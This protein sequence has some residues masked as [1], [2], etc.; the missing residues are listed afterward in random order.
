MDLAFGD[1][2]LL[3]PTV[4][5]LQ[6]IFPATTSGSKTENISTKLPKDVHEWLMPLLIALSKANNEFLSNFVAFSL[7]RIQQFDQSSGNVVTH[8]HAC[9]VYY[10]LS[11]SSKLSN[12]QKEWKIKSELDYISLL[13]VCLNNPSM[14]NQL[15]LP[16]IID[17]VEIPLTDLKDKLRRFSNIKG[18]F[19]KVKTQ[20]L[21]EFSQN[22]ETNF[23][24]LNQQFPLVAKQIQEKQTEVDKSISVWQ[25]CPASFTHT[26]KFGEFIGKV[27]H[28]DEGTNQLNKNFMETEPNFKD[29][30][31][32]IHD[33]DVE[34][35][36]SENDLNGSNISEAL[37]SSEEASDARTTGVRELS[38][39]MTRDISKNIWIF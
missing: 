17:N 3:V 29:D 32:N 24:Y 18:L 23:E 12:E 25:K 15:F 8:F 33:D 27:Q 21:N 13:E 35:E 10:I 20:R 26:Y 4:D 14:Y 16:L 30:N 6:E 2:G 9:W 37:S 38:E 39:K 36:L 7:K 19:N 22:E 31:G 28:Q 5:T 11:N 34:S 1:E